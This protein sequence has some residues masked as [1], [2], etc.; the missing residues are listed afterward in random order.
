MGTRCSDSR[1]KAQK[2]IAVPSDISLAIS[3]YN[4]MSDFT[5]CLF[6]HGTYHTTYKLM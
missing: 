3:V 6:R 5:A 2:G 4:A 1:Y